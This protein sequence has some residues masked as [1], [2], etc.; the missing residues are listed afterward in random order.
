MLPDN[1]PEAL[2]RLVSL[3]ATPEVNIRPVLLRV[4]VDLFVSRPSHGE[5]AVR[6]FEEIA[7]RL[8]DDA[9]PAAHLIVA[10]KLAGHPQAPKTMLHRLIAQRGDVAVTVLARAELEAPALQ[11]AAALGTTAM[12]EAVAG[13]P[14]LDPVTLRALADRPEPAVLTK[15]AGNPASVSDEGTY[16]YLVRRARDR[17]GVAQRL[18]DQGGDPI[19]QAALFM[20]ATRDQRAAILLA[21]RRHDLALPR[22]APVPGG[23]EACE[24][25]ARVV[26]RPGMD[27]LD[28]ILCQALDL[29]APLA[30]QIVDDPGGEPMAVAL[31]A[32]G[33]SPELAARLFILGPPVIGHSY[34]AVKALAGLV[35][36]VSPGAARRLVDSI[37]GDGSAVVRRRAVRSEGERSEPVTRRAESPAAVITPAV[38]LRKAG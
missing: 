14:N 28:L 26:L 8:L 29:P 35:E 18:L 25:L 33:A 1:L 30:E 37:R 7:M 11:A 12:A 2:E 6:Q 17:H 3:G 19:H 36:T 27:G 23:P 24:K 21:L 16:R 15:L 13:R 31:A 20:S 22:S 34:V 5:E 32:L 38:P 4:L 9:E 10:T